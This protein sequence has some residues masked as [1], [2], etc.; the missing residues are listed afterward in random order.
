MK[1]AYGYN[2]GPEVFTEHAPDSIV[3]DTP[4]DK[5]VNRSQLFKSGFRDDDKLIIVSWGNLARGGE[6]PAFVKELDQLGIPVS[7]VGLP[8]KEAHPRGRP[9]ALS[10]ICDEH[11][12][13]AKAMWKD[14]VRHTQLAVREFVRR[15][16][17][18]MP[19]R[20]QLHYRYGN[21]T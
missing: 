1:I 18:T 5:R 9:N 3:I 10:L 7:V 11:D 19:T 12:A 21:R 6:L 8:Q 17:G 15:K 20:H 4:K 14:P 16:I 13:E 2:V